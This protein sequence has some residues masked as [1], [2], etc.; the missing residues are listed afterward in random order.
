MGRSRKYDLVIM[1]ATGFTGRL[2]AEYLAVNYGVKNDQ[3]TWAIAGRNKSRLLKLKGHLV[4]FD[5]DAGSLPIL[6]AESSDR[7]SLDAMTSQTKVVITTV[8][9]YLKYGAELVVSCAENG[10]NYCDITGEVLFIRNSIDRNFKT[11]RQ[12][13]CRIVHCCGF[14][15]VPSDLGVLFL[16]DNSQKIYGMPCDHVTL[17]VRST[18]GGLS[19]GT[20]DSMLN[21][22][23][24]LR[25]DLKLRG[26]LGNPYALNPKEYPSGPDESDLRSVEWDHRMK[27]WTGPFVM[28]GI[29]TRVVRRT[30]A[31]LNN[32]YGADFRYSE[33][34]SFPN[35]AVGWMRANLL[36]LGMG[37]FIGAIKFSLSR[38][39]LQ[40]I[41]LPKPGQGPSR[42]KR[43]NGHFHMMI[44]GTT[45]NN[46]ILRVNVKGSRDPG[47]AG[48]AQ[49]LTESAL[50]MIMN[51]DELPDRAGVLTPAAAFGDTPI[52]RLAGKGI[53]FKYH[54]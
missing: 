52:K 23:D 24:Q 10:T 6:I 28:A 5:P 17:Y 54:E 38:W 21:T 14:D 46:N 3:F 18:K 11:A 33:V 30:N 8:G 42:K 19:G 22:R 39:L 41:F 2:T 13:L 36:L 49:M 31:L 29:N 9:P 48:T 44:V 15:S 43:D 20:I 51:K 12:N 27:C 34:L 25:M 1:G 35:G 45:K 40:N 53:E 4:R 50:C 37:C 16:Q 47:Y 7:E 32:R 26:L